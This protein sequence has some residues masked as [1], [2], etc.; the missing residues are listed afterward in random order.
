MPRLQGLFSSWVAFCQG[1]RGGRKPTPPKFDLWHWRKGEPCPWIFLRLYFLE[2]GLRHMQNQF[3]GMLLSTAR[4]WSGYFNLQL[5]KNFSAPSLSNR[6][7]PTASV[8]QVRDCPI[9]TIYISLYKF[10][11]VLPGIFCL[12]LIKIQ[13]EDLVGLYRLQDESFEEETNIVHPRW[14]DEKTEVRKRKRLSKILWQNYNCFGIRNWDLRFKSS[15]Q[16]AKRWAHWLIWH[17]D[18]LAVKSVHKR[19][20]H[21]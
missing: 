8:T 14:E 1:F 3:H 2:Q 13:K 12:F 6:G 21:M 15:I 16:A 5:G 9:I 10:S 4:R 11:I 19:P 18:Y 20:Y 17:H 7:M